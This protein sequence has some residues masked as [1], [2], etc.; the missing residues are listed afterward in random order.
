MDAH[1]LTVVT[2]NILSSALADP[3]W[4]TQCDPQHLVAE[5]RLARV[6]VKLGLEMDKGAVILLQEV[7][8]DWSGKLH[9]F[10]HQREYTFIDSLY[11]GSSSGYMGV[12]IAFPNGTWSVVDVD[13]RRVSETKAEWHLPSR[14][15]WR[16]ARGE[17]REGDW[18]CP[19]AAC[20]AHVFANK[21][22]CYKCKTAKPAPPEPA[23][24]IKAI[25]PALWAW[26]SRA[27]APGTP[28]S[29]APPGARSGQDSSQGQ[30]QDLSWYDASHRKENTMVAV[31]LQC[32]AQPE[33][34][35]WFGT[36]HMPCAFMQPKLM[37]MHA[38]LA[39][40]HLQQLAATTTES[41]RRL[42]AG[43]AA[44]AAAGAPPA[45]PA[46]PRSTPCLFGGDWNLK[47]TDPLYL[48]LTSGRMD[49]A[50]AQHYPKPPAG[51]AW[52]PDLACGM[53]SAYAA[54]HGGCEPDFTNYAQ[55]CK[56]EAPFVG[57]LDY[58]P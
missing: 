52:L 14:D 57:C 36:Y 41:R 23:S 30:A 33:V 19:N 13:I 37:A 21:V 25:L 35:A 1:G 28:G 18:T 27:G 5:T 47:P 45:P 38:A 39:M 11:G 48:L 16:P 15:Q 55:C 12:G 2:Y 7:S 46:A 40:Q 26:L 9:A 10:F 51:D 3:G 6:L 58:V 42:H 31:H 4:F 22:A 49:P 17:P 53:A 29:Q 8:R 24:G 44:G 32:K 43:A 20:R 56:D 50:L 54:A 34:D